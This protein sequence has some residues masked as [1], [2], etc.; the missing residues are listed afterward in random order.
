MSLVEYIRD[1]K[2]FLNLE[3]WRTKEEGDFLTVLLIKGYGH[4]RSRRAFLQ[5]CSKSHRSP[6]NSSKNAWAWVRLGTQHSRLC[7]GPWSALWYIKFPEKISRKEIYLSLFSLTFPE[8]VWWLSLMSTIRP[9]CGQSWPW[10]PG[11]HSH[12][13]FLMTACTCEVWS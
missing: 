10:L 13:C 1:A 8:L 11:S 4:Y 6:E 2:D 12:V 9:H 3:T 7:T 5:V